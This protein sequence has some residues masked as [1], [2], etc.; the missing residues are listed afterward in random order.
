MTQTF[1]NTKYFMT[2]VC[3]LLYY[4]YN[5]RR[6]GGPTLLENIKCFEDY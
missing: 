1:K 2:W 4:V 3:D 5:S 6:R